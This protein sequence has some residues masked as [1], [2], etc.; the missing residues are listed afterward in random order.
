MNEKSTEPT[1]AFID[2]RLKAKQSA[3]D[4]VLNDPRMPASVAGMLSIYKHHES[5]K[6]RALLH[7][8]SD[9]HSKTWGAASS[10]SPFDLTAI[11]SHPGWKETEKETI[12]FHGRLFQKVDETNWREIDAS[13]VIVVQNRVF[14]Q[15][16]KRA[17]RTIQSIRKWY[18][19]NRADEAEGLPK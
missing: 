14:F 5:E 1:Q 6:R 12:G 15:I 17:H 8:E 10:I 19:K 18:E 2:A 7:A 16:D 13:N 11:S 4:A 3:A 9:F